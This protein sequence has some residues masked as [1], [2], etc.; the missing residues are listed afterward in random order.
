[1][2][3]SK[4]RKTQQ[5][6]AVTRELLLRAAEQVFARDGY[7]KAQVDQI[8]AEAGFSKGGLYAHFESKEELFLALYQIKTA[9][10]QAT[11]RQA[12]D[13][14][15]TREE[16]INA[17]RNFYIDLSKDKEW[18][19]IVLEVKLL[20]RRHPEVRS[21]IRQI[22]EHV[23]ETI[24]ASLIKLFGASARAAGEALGGI[25]SALVLQA[26]LEPAVL[27]ERKMRTMLGAIFDALL[28][29]R[30]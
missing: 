29:A 17:F 9:S 6:T 25:S 10:Y 24:D 2:N 3:T 1:M 27:T 16:R 5:R 15:S 7:E 30:A 4:P 12:L 19:L 13:G 14:V 26:D 28:R 22:D 20:V 23:A 8:A 18:A 21:K 11:L